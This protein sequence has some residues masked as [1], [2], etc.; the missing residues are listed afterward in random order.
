MD[1]LNFFIN[2]DR[3][4]VIFGASVRDAISAST[5]NDIDSEFSSP[6]KSAKSVCQ[7]FTANK[8]A[9]LTINDLLET[10]TV[11]VIDKN[12]I[13]ESPMDFASWNKTMMQNKT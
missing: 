9:K 12:S 2:N 7:I 13:S 5:P 8:F 4:P 11:G 6:Y 3:Q 1:V 10:L